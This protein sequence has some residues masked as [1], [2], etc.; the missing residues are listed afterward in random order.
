[1]NNICCVCKNSLAD[2]KYDYD[3]I[4][5][6]SFYLEPEKYQPIGHINM[7]RVDNVVLNLKL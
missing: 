7:S 5:I 1:M 4:N 2:E 3:G 6:Y